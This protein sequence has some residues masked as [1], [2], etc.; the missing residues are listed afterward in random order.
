MLQ[1]TLVLC[2]IISFSFSS[3]LTNLYILHVALFLIH[4]LALLGISSVTPFIILS[5]TFLFIFSFTIFFG[6]FVTLLLWNRLIS[7]NFNSATFFPGN[8]VNLSVPHSVTLLLILCVTLLFM[9]S[10]IVWHLDSVA[11]LPGL[12]PALILPDCGA[13]RYPTVGT[14][15]QKQKS[16]YLHDFFKMKLF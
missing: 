13:G 14:P 8:V 10:H 9:S 1:I 16:Q 2:Y 7:G 3:I 6:Y 11:L 4:S 5:V 15:K 12:I